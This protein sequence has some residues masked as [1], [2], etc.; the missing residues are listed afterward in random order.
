MKISCSCAVA[1]TAIFWLCLNSAKAEIAVASLDGKQV[2]PGD[3]GPTPD[4]V[5]VLDITNGTVKLLG[6]VDVPAAMIGPPAAIAVSRDSTFAL[7]TACQKLV[8]GKL[9]PD[10]LLSVIDL[11]SPSHPKVL[12][13]LHAGPGATGVS[14]SPDGRLALV[15]STREDAISVFS[16][17]GKTLK[18]LRKVAIR[19]GSDATDVVFTPDGKTALVVSE[20]DSTIF[21]L[22]VD[23]MNVTNTGRSFS[24]G[25]SPYGAVVT[26][27]GR[28]V[29][30][31]NL[32]G[33]NP[34]PGGMK[35]ATAAGVRIG[36][37]GVTDIRT[38]RAVTSTEVGP[39]PEHV[40]MSGDGKYIAVVVANGAANDRSNPKWN[41]TYG[42]FK[43]FTLGDGTL[44]PVASA[45]AGHWCQGA[46][47]AAD[48]RT[49]I[50]ECAGERHF[51]IFH[52]DGKHLVQDRRAAIG[53][54]SRPGAIATA[55][56]R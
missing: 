48:D 47:I 36:A 14:I 30:T 32:H 20:A 35:A 21:V 11:A 52:L 8:D 55:A 54:L 29:L 26:P 23:G 22:A 40:V 41:T 25:L 17:S 50:L 45:R 44:T 1:L 19:A 38:G 24:P 15:A 42:L 46:T 31:T 2:H 33:P 56:S 39:T 3:R 51:E 9:V 12:Q 37:I 28:Y 13:T 5:A 53:T 16:I 10:D 6:M 7:A 43:V 18:P 34:R 27:D 49:F 4:S